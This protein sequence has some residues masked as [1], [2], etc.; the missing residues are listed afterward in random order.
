MV[1]GG[2]SLT[3]TISTANKIGLVV[4]DGTA[5][6]NLG[7]GVSNMSPTGF[8]CCFADFNILKPDGT[9]L[10][11]GTFG[12]PGAE[13]DLP[14]LPSNGTYTVVIDPRGGNTG[15]FTLVLTSH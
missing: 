14:I 11:S 10:S 13:F 7:L 2:A 9:V 4:F 8:G 12:D 5:G 3:A 15:S 6:Q 1:I